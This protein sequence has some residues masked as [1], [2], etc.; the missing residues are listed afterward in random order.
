MING[1]DISHHQGKMDWSKIKTDFVIIKAT[2]GV[3]FLDP[4]FKENQ[5][6][7]RKAGILLGYY[8]FAN[9]QDAKK[10]ADHFLKTVGELR[11]GELLVLDYEIDL[12]NAAAWC[13]TFLDRCFEKTGIKPILYTNEARVLSINWDVVIK[14]DYG[15]W[16]AKYGSNNGQPGKEPATGKWSFYVLWQYTSNGKVTGYPNRVDKNQGTISL[17]TLKKYG[18]QAP[19][20]THCCPKHCEP[21]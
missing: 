6:G 16:V 12:N 14:G 20:C 2:Q 17:E 10:E 3:S 7:V 13:K 1:I 11:E 9:G 8:H 18:K 15:L 4:R 5:A 19:K 21:K